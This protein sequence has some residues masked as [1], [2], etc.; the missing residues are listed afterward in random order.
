MAGKREALLAEAIKDNTAMFTSEDILTAAGID[1]Q[2]ATELLD[3][4]NN[5]MTDI[6]GEFL[7]EK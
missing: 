3:K 5:N 7:R 6:I 1:K 4:V 2:K